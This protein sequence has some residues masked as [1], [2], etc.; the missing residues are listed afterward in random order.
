MQIFIYEKNGMKINPVL[1]KG[2]I[3]IVALFGCMK[4]SNIYYSSATMNINSKSFDFIG[5]EHN[6]GLDYVFSNT[7][8][9]NNNPRFSDD[10]KSV[11]KYVYEVSPITSSSKD[12]RDELFNSETRALL[13]SSITSRSIIIDRT[14]LIKK[15][16]PAQFSMIEKLDGAFSLP[17]VELQLSEIKSLKE[18]AINTLNNDEIVFVLSSLSLAEYSLIYWSGSKGEM[19]KDRIMEI[20]NSRQGSLKINGENINMNV[21]SNKI[22]WH[23]VA[24]VD[25]GAFIAGFPAGVN[26]GVIVGGLTAGIASGGVA[27]G[28]GAVLGGIVGGTASGIATAISASAIVLA[29][30][31]IVDWF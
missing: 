27:A 26:V 4:S 2:A 7:L 8:Q 13:K 12:N 19:W 16:T 1:I 29:A 9:N 5:V 17:D 31:F 30:E 23:N 14:A 28:V 24:V 20:S 11:D 25:V 6:N 22:D 18:E 15:L 10:L 3:I 21:K